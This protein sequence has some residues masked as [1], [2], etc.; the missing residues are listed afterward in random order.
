MKNSNIVDR[1]VERLKEQPLGDL[2][3][4]EDFY[5]IKKTIPKTFFEQEI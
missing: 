5:N 4:E 3:K 2:I 1:V